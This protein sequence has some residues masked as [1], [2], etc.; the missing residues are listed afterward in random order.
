MHIAKLSVAICAAAALS[1]AICDASAER[2]AF[3]A[4]VTAFEQSLAAA[5]NSTAAYKVIY[6]GDVATSPIAQLYSRPSTDKFTYDLQARN[7]K[8][9]AA[10]ARVRCVTDASGAVSTLSV[11]PAGEK[12]PVLAADF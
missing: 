5:G 11:L 12:A 7:P 4:C 1:P 10:F 6:H 2:T 3:H 9:G 8:T